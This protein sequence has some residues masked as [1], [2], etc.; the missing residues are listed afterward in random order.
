MS[1]IMSNNAFT[2]DARGR[3]LTGLALVTLVSGAGRTSGD[4]TA[5]GARL[6][7]QSYPGYTL[8]W[9][10]EFDRDGSPDQANW[11]FENG[12]V[13]NQELQ[14][15][16]PDNA[17]VEAGH[18]VIAGRRERRPNPNYV[19]GSSDWKRNREF[20][21]FTSSSLITRGLHQWQYGRIEMRGRID[22]RPGM[23]PAFWTLGAGGAWP[24]NG[25]VDIM[26]YYR[27]D[28]LANAAWGGA[29]RGQAIWDDSRTP[30][31][32]LG[33]ADWAGRFHV[34]RMEWDED[35]IQLFVDDRLLNEIDLKKTVNE[36]GSGRNPFRQPHYLIVNLAI[37]G[38]G[39][40]PGTTGFPARFEV[41][42]IRVY[43]KAGK[44]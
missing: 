14:W 12:F 36:D 21:E 40:D 25:E 15:Y 3:L 4:Q 37:G 34:W 8:V 31:A 9:A 22:V 42:Y 6:P 7:A 29:K 43:Q 10:D 41:D 38:Q 1:G 23:W 44:G 24:H 32:S 16:Q 13:R 28:L 20:A 2:R 11:N 33:G 18:L 39:G 35:L 26:E 30:I 17:R 27:G 5:G 19:A